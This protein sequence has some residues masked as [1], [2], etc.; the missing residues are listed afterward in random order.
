MTTKTKTF[1]CV[2]MKQRIQE[3]LRSEY[4]SRKKEF[5]SYVDFLNAKAAQSQWVKKIQDKH[6]TKK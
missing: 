3:Q 6:L 5:A 1:D 2:E 4:E